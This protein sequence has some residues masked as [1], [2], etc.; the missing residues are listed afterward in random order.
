MPTPHSH[1]LWWPSGPISRIWFTDDMRL[2]YVLQSSMFSASGSCRQV[3]CVAPLS[4]TGRGLGEVEGVH[5]KER[6]SILPCRL[7]SHELEHFRRCWLCPSKR[8]QH[9]IR[10]VAYAGH[11]DDSTG[12]HLRW[13]NLGDGGRGAMM[14]LPIIVRH[15]RPASWKH[16]LGRLV[17][18]QPRKMPPSGL[19]YASSDSSM[20]SN[21]GS[22]QSSV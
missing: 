16:S 9:R 3:S 1:A 4:G 7:V 14:L 19:K 21:Q 5:G 12:L 2:K 11:G 6:L 20:P 18:Q 13:A 22:L 8:S 10:T 15:S 17:L